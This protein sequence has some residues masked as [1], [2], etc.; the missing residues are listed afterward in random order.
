M[1]ALLLNSADLSKKIKKVTSESEF[2]RHMAKQS[3]PE[4]HRCSLKKKKKQGTQTTG[5]WTCLK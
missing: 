2:D 4:K 3:S 1:Q 5:V